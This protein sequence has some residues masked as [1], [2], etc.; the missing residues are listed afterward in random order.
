MFV[1]TNMPTE[2]PFKLIHDRF[3]R[4]TEIVCIIVKYCMSTIKEESSQSY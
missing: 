1:E 2:P 4:N 3:Q